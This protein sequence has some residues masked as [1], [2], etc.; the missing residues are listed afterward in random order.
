MK[1]VQMT[2]RR[3]TRHLCEVDAQHPAVQLSAV[4]VVDGIR[5]IRFVLILH[6]AE[7]P[8]VAW[9]SHIPE[10]LRIPS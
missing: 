4:H 5:G 8:V 1:I 2:E 6:E 9:E 10:I 3:Q 7:S